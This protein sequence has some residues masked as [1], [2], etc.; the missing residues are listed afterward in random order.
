LA[1]DVAGSGGETLCHEIGHAAATE[2]AARRGEDFETTD[3]REKGRDE[4]RQAKA[5]AEKQWGVCERSCEGSCD[6]YKDPP[7][8]CPE[9]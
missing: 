8:P 9:R 6:W 3:K 2:R 1:N 5:D 4:S 7:R